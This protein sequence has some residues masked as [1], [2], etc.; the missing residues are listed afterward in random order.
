MLPLYGKRLGRLGQDLH[1]LFWYG[2]VSDSIFLPGQ[3]SMCLVLEGVVFHLISPFYSILG[4]REGITHSASPTHDSAGT[5]ERPQ[6]YSTDSQGTLQWTW[7]EYFVSG[8]RLCL[9][10]AR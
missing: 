1:G 9:G 7:D 6:T 5:N 8:I 3:A 10:A 2:K 4:N